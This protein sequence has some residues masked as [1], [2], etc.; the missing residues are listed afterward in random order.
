MRGTKRILA[1]AISAAVLTSSVQAESPKAPMFTPIQTGATQAPGAYA[2]TSRYGNTGAV[3]MGA[4]GYGQTMGQGTMGQGTM[5]GQM[6]IQTS[7]QTGLQPNPLISSGIPTGTGMQGQSGSYRMGT[8]MGTQSGVGLQMNMGI[9]TQ[10]NPNMMVDPQLGLNDPMMGMGGMHGGDP[11]ATMDAPGITNPFSIRSLVANA[12]SRVSPQELD[13][14]KAAVQAYVDG[15]MGDSRKLFSAVTER[16]PEGIATDRAYLGLAKIERAYGAYDVSRRIL[17][18]VIRKNRDYESIM[19]ARRSYRDLQQ[20]V[21]SSA[22]TAQRDMDMAYAAYKQTSWWNIFSKIKL[23]NAYKDSKANF[24]GLLISSKQF[25]DIFAQTN[26]STPIPGGNVPGQGAGEQ[27]QQDPEVPG[28]VQAQ[29]DGALTLDQLKAEVGNNL[30]P[31]TQQ[32]TFLNPAGQATQA[33]PVTAAPPVVAE[34]VVAAT[35]PK[36]EPA[37]TPVAT[38]PAQVD[39]PAAS[40]EKPINEMSMDE[41]RESYLTIYEKLKEA[42]K[43]DDAKLKQKLQADYKAALQRYNELRNKN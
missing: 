25:D 14:L 36:V 33:A 9:G 19:L 20:E 21:I 34:P 22:N 6:G 18:A 4:T 41:A 35:P 26:I 38:P 1:F 5:G 28:D 16:F 37:P 39:G 27:G 40:T 31:A 42:L 12:N 15:N 11:M 30:P 8:G 43:G 2:A 29:I 7:M 13:A 24:E 32:P 17:E 23:Y 10:S 3:G